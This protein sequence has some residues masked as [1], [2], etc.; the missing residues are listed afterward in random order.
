MH[1]PHPSQLVEFLSRKLGIPKEE[2]PEAGDWAG[3]G[4]T[5]GSLALRMGVLSLEQI[6]HVVDLQVSGDERFGETAVTLGFLGREQVDMLMRLQGLHRCVD[7]AG[8]LVLSGQLEL[9]RMAALLS[10]FLG[11]DAV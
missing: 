1:D 9:D 10:E 11:P 8:P 3:S 5:I 2:L 7:L 6:E 4:N